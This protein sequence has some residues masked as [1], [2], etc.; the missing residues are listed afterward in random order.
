MI[1]MAMR[2]SEV[3]RPIKIGAH[4]INP[5]AKAFMDNLREISYAHPFDNAAVILYGSVS[6]TARAMPGEVYL[7]AIE[8]FDNHKQGLA[9]KALGL[10]KQLADHHDI[11][12]RG[13]VKAY[14][15]SSDH[16]RSDKRLLQWYKKNGFSVE[17]KTIRYQPA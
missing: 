3:T 12:I 5:N 4:K 10:L 6:I 2:I 1:N 15:K 11:P 13:E 8:T 17:G 16:I 14:S 7:S 9:S